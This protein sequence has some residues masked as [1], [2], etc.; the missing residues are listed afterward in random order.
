MESQRNL[1]I[2]CIVGM[3]M[4]LIGALGIGLILQMSFSPTMTPDPT[5]MTLLSGAVGI[6]LGSF[7][8]VVNSEFKQVVQDP[9]QAETIATLA[10][11]NGT[12]T[13]SPEPGPT[14]HAA[15]ASAVVDAMQAV[16]DVPQNVTLTGVSA[17]VVDAV[18]K[19]AE[20]AADRQ[21]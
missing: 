5:L 16:K 10:T 14:N 2:R 15:I 4:L 12:F 13:P 20:R 18:D 6:V 8:T 11:G 17:E 9:A 19:A 7:G 1:L 3:V 21:Q